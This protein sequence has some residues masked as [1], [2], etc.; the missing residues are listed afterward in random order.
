M[1]MQACPGTDKIL[2]AAQANSLVAVFESLPGSEKKEQCNEASIFPGDFAGPAQR[3][4]AGLSHCGRGLSVVHRSLDCT[5]N[6]WHHSGSCHAERA[7]I[8]GH[9]FRGSPGGQPALEATSAGRVLVG[10]TQRH[11]LRQ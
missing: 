8:P 4:D 1:S 3:D 10:D 7:T 9:S 5:D 6:K 2:T 11:Q